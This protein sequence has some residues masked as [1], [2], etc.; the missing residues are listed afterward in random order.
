MASNIITKN[1]V[2]ELREKNS[3]QKSHTSNASDDITGDFTVNLPHEV[4]LEEGDVV[5]VQSVFIDDEGEN[6]NTILIEEDITDGSIEGY[7][8][9]MD[10]NTSQTDENTTSQGRVGGQTL[11][12]AR[13]YHPAFN[14]T[15]ANRVHPDGEPYFLASI[16]D[17]VG[18]GQSCLNFTVQINMLLNKGSPVPVF[19]QYGTTAGQTISKV[20]VWDYK[21]INKIQSAAGILTVSNGLLELRDKKLSDDFQFPFDYNGTLAF[22]VTK[23][24]AKQMS[25]GGVLYPRGITAQNDPLT[26]GHKCSLFLRTIPFT[27]K[28]GSYSPEHIGQ[29]ITDQIVK[30][31][32]SGFISGQ[33]EQRFSNN[34]FFTTALDL[35]HHGDKADGSR[36]NG[37]HRPFLIRTDG[38][39]A[40]QFDDTDL[41]GGTL[42]NY[43]A[44]ASNF[45]LSFD[46]IRFSFTN[47]HQSIY[48]KQHP[49]VVGARVG[50]VAANNNYLANKVSGICFSQLKP[51]DLW[52]NKL[53]FDRDML[54]HPKKV[55]CAWQLPGGHPGATQFPVGQV[56]FSAASG[57]G[58]LDNRIVEGK[59]A[60]GDLNSL[61]AVVV[62]DDLPDPDR[63]NGAYDIPGATG[64]AGVNTNIISQIGILAGALNNTEEGKSYY[65]IEIDMNVPSE[66][67][68]ANSYNNKIQAIIGRYYTS[69]SGTQSVGGEGAITYT[70]KGEPIKLNQFR[71]RILAPDGSLARVGD[72][73]TV[74]LNITKAK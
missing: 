74:F 7:I 23:D 70:H 2:V 1:V 35:R 46:G 24:S 17:A 63:G 54:V 25:L 73:N 26:A 36:A 10:N 30:L 15:P 51:A 39:K 5:S 19:F 32:T 60:T 3:N 65:Q 22:N 52:F 37:G 43:W 55:T 68:G 49:V 21:T 44:G 50:N 14:A 38:A 58:D 45:G 41:G 57:A 48:H 18:G 20:V 12:E 53:G 11:G 66:K 8:Y 27:L 16:D 71:I 72:D 61:D 56:A 67:L 40:F 69:G 64:L 9:H 6:D 33:G 42:R 47:L 13:T 4:D 34:D 28:A 31:S 29:L 62:K 59:N